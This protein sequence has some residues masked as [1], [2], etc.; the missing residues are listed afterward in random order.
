[1]KQQLCCNPL[2]HLIVLFYKLPI[3]IIFPLSVVYGI[4]GG[5]LF[6]CMNS[7]IYAWMY[8]YLCIYVCRGA[9]IYVYKS[10]DWLCQCEKETN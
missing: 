8:V 10:G 5:A 2:Y 7:C 6:V 3:T 1:M 4:M 9:C